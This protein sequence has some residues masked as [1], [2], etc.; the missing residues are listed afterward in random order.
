MTF[1]PVVLQPG[2]NVEATATLNQAGILRSLNLRFK[3]GLAQKL[4]GWVKYVNIA[5]SG[6]IK[7]LWGWQDLNNVKRLSVASTQAVTVIAQ[8]GIPEVITPQKLRTDSPVSFSTTAGSALVVVNDPNTSGLTTDDTVELLTPISVDDLILS[9]IYAI[10]IINGISSYT[11]RAGSAATATVGNSGVVPQFTTTVGSAA[12]VVTLPNHK[13]LKGNPVVFPIPTIVGGIT[14]QGKYSVT[15]VNSTTQFEITASSG[16]VGSASGFM[17]GGLAAFSYNIALGPVASGFGFGLGAYGA[18]AYGKGTSSGAAQV[19]VP[20][21][22]TDWTQDNWGEILLSCPENGGIYYWQPNTGF[23]NLSL[24]VTGPIYNTGMFVSMAQ[25]QVIAYG[26]SVDAREIGGIGIYQDPMLIGWCDIG[27]FF[28]WTPDQANFARN[29]RVP[30]GSLCVG[31]SASK[32]RNL[33]W[34]DLDVHAGT[35]NGGQ[36]VYSWNR[37]GSNCGLIGKHAH[38]QQADTDYWMGV[39]NFFSYAGSGVQPIPCSVWD[40]VFDVLDATFQSRV[41]CASDSDFT[42]IWWFYPTFGSAGRLDRYAK[43]NVIE[44]VWDNGFMDRCAWL[45]RS[46]LGNPLGASSAGLVYSHENGYDDDTNAMLPLF[47]T[48]DFYI[49]EGEEFVFIDQVIPDFKWGKSGAS[50]NAQVQITL[51][52]R[53]APGVPYREYGPYTCTKEMPFFNPANPDGTRP[54]TRQ[55]ALRVQSSDVGSFW[56]LGK[57]RFRQAP[58]GRR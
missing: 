28:Q 31:G 34:T 53:D 30:T 51:L 13:Q 56:R 47:E 45:D 20:I 44:G 46:V 33:V 16:A 6:T 40:D 38:A 24:I 26:T 22:A 17:N 2:V 42:E 35:F 36:S 39:G 58:D 49:S 41:M 9:G 10:E 57:I 8:G 23:Q 7:S 18:G 4:G 3:Q 55:I 43:Y 15:R 5:F 19:G 50:Q 32:N 1:T 37:V 12:V 29:Y 52:C 14:I 48:G 27:D 54:R 21:T 11:I 25:Q